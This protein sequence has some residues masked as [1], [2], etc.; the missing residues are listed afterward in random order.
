MSMHSPTRHFLCDICGAAFKT[1]ACQQKHIKFIHQNPRSYKCEVCNKTFNTKYTA[2]RHSR[3]H[4][5]LPPNQMI[6]DPECL[7]HEQVVTH[8]SQMTSQLRAQ[9]ASQ[10]NEQ[11][12]SHTLLHD[13]D[14]Q[15]TDQL[16]SQD[17]IAAPTMEEY[18]QANIQ[19]N[20]NVTAIMYLSNLNI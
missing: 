5:P 12:S 19:A 1:R 4:D 7:V 2:Q 15:A 3:V 8:M 14:N 9:V 11:M 16:M 13:G 20:E 10:L 18:E 17:I 6:A